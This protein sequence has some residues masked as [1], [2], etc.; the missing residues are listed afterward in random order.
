[1]VSTLKGRW[2]SVDARRWAGSTLASGAV[3]A[4][5]VMICALW[6]VPLPVRPGR[7]EIRTVWAEGAPDVLLDAVPL[8]VIA[9]DPDAGGASAGAAVFEHLQHQVE[10]VPP[11]DITELPPLSNPDGDTIDPQSF[12]ELVSLAGRAGAG[13]AGPSGRGEGSGDSF[14]SG[15]GGSAFFGQQVQG[16]RVVYVVDASRSMNHPH[17][18][19]MKTRFGR[20]KLELIRSISRMTPEQQFFIVY[21]ND[22]ALPMPAN[23]MAVAT[24]AAR[25]KFLR[26]AAQIRADGF[27]NPEQALALALRLRPDVIYFL[28]DGNF[29][30]RIV[31]QV[32][33]A[34]QNRVVIHTIGFADDEGEDLLKTIAA[35]NWGQYQ[36]IPADEVNPD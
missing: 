4:A 24:P 7:F 2:R 26:W 36:F 29:P 10:D 17:P 30:A 34:N 6:L 12:T 13:A 3:H 31:K 15:T 27:T 21:F 18:G 22:R 20:V 25:D 28:T 35:Q 19:P 5:A 23:A 16:R 14:G 33:E 11:I 9:A 8:P 1:M 32:A